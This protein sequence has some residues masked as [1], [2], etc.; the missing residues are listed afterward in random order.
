MNLCVT[1]IIRCCTGQ[2]DFLVIDLIDI[3]LQHKIFQSGMHSLHHSTNIKILLWHFKCFEMLIGI[4]C[5]ILH[6]VLYDYILENG[7]KWT[8]WCCR[9][10][11]FISLSEWKQKAS[12]LYCWCI[13][14][15]WGS[16][17]LCHRFEH[18]QHCMF[19]HAW[20]RMWMQIPVPISFECIYKN[21]SWR[22]GSW[23]H[24]SMAYLEWSRCF[25]LSH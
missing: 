18:H 8:A 20:K 6:T 10:F 19:C 25:L 5:L 16:I 15:W 2:E 13:L 7:S 9:L 21:K 22:L 14:G 17:M 23:S 24:D 11:I 1:M 4:S 3:T 12:Y